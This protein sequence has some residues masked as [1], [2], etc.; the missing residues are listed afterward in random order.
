MSAP[1]GREE[2]GVFRKGGRAGP[3]SIH[4]GLRLREAAVAVIDAWRRQQPDLPT[5]QEAIR[6]LVELGL[7]KGKGGKR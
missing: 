7:A 1:N 3:A 6:R 5:R 4:I 2:L